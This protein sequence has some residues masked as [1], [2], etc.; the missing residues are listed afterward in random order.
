MMN[1]YTLKDIEVAWKKYE[2]ESVLRVMKE[3]K[4][5]TIPLKGRGIPRITATQAKV[6]KLK[7]IISFPEYLKQ[8]EKTK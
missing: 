1:K 4:W 8:N 6:A 2:S 5:K 3:G 7:D